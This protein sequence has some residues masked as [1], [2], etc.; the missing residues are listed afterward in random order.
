MMYTWKIQTTQKDA[1]FNQ[2]FGINTTDARCMYNIANFYIRNTMTGIKKSP[3]LR[4]AN[5]TEVLHYVFTGIQQANVLAIKRWNEKVTRAKHYPNGLKRHNVLSKLLKNGPTVF[6]YPT[7]KKWFLGYNVLDAIFKIHKNPVYCRMNSQVNQNAIRKVVKSWESYFAQIKDYKATPWKYQARPSLPKYLKDKTTA[8]FTNQTA[9]LIVQ[10]GKVYLKFVN[11]NNMFYIG[12]Q[13]LYQGLTYVKAEIKPSHGRYCVC[14]TF[15][16]DR[17]M[18]EVPEHP[19]RILG[20]DVGIDNFLAVAGNFGDAPFLIKGGALKSEN[21]LFNKKRAHLTSSLT[22]GKDSTHSVKNSKQLSAVSRK[23]EDF[24]RDF[25]YKTAW[26]ICRYAKKHAVEVIVFGHNKQQKQEVPLGAATNQ[27]LVSIPFCTFQSI[28]ATVAAKCGIPVVVRE[29]SYTS[30]A[31]LLDMDKIPTYGSE[32]KDCPVFSGKRIKRGLYCS[33]NGILINA[34]VNGAGNILRKE[35]PDAFA[36][37]EDLSYLYKT[38][39]SVGCKTLYP[40][41]KSICS[42]GYNGKKHCPGSDSSCRQFYRKERKLDLQ[43]AM[44][45][46]KPDYKTLAKSA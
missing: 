7:P 5:E 2:Y 19:E 46:E 12:K 39:R 38:T 16:D 33:K 25:F 43:H 15:N 11:L 8:W 44:Y 37:Q 3:E 13:S 45:V 22:K 10:D 24:I 26:Y 20:I 4:T 17:E 29:E 23:R 41:A 40:N 30:K 31:S 34:D 28:L 6:K 35:Y 27:Q 32:G 14:I 42:P 21:Q 9:K 1:V 36:G 18:P